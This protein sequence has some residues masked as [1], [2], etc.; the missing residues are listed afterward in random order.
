[1]VLFVILFCPRVQHPVNFTG[2]TAKGKNS[3]G[4]LEGALT[5]KKAAE[6]VNEPAYVLPEDEMILDDLQVYAFLSTVPSS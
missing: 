6:L 5:G 2:R 1:M 4:S 3:W